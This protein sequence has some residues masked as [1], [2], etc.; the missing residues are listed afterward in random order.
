MSV[1]SKQVFVCQECGAVYAKWQGR[2][3]ACGEWNSVV[4]EVQTVSAGSSAGLGNLSSG[5]APQ[6]IA[7]VSLQEV[8]RLNVGVEELNLVL[9][10]GL[11]PGS[12]TLLGGE[13]GIGKSTILLQLAL[14]VS[15]SHGRVLYVS[16]E[17]SAPQV[18]M[19]AE[20]L[21]AL[22]DELWLLTENNL[23]VILQQAESQNCRLL[24]V[25]SIQ[26]VFLPELSSAPGSVAQVRQCGN[27]LMKLA[28]ERGV[29]V[30]LVGHV[31]KDGNLAGPRV[32]E[33]MVDTVLYFEGDR[34]AN[35][36]LLRA[37]KNRFGSTNELGVFEMTETGLHAL[38]DPSAVFLT[39]RD[40]PVSGA[41]VGCVQQ[42][43]RPV[44]LEI[45]ALTSPTSFGN[46]RRLASGFDYNR[47]LIIIAVLEKKVGLNLGNQDIYVNI[48][49]GLRVDD[50]AV[51][52]AVAAAIAS[53]YWERPL[54]ADLVAMGEIGLTGEL[55]PVSQPEQRFREAVR[56][57]FD[58]VVAAPLKSG[59]AAAKK[60]DLKLYNAAN[61]QIALSFMGLL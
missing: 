30:V 53:A 11:V 59:K 28:K 58:N 27:E 4:E 34:M 55:R 36:R 42:G 22:A 50:P 41:A 3:T 31:T 18:R 2:C 20:R 40:Q 45:Q 38:S 61:L 57:G 49:G 21:C 5:S 15:Q 7:K 9:G 54:P 26:T 33:H 52:L 46:A 10:G 24:I 35:L 48:T 37:I 1:K 16:G 14:A 56:L 19:R 60:L 17:E 39:H 8:A 25:D 29:A 44:L 6:P 13:P 51:D 23:Q 47:M 32:L 12:L 43:A